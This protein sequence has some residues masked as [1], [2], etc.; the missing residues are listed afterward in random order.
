MHKF[1]HKAYL[2]LRAVVLPGGKKKL[3]T[4]FQQVIVEML[5]LKRKNGQDI[6]FFH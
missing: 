3:I 1:D 2:T 4:R 6:D 5:S